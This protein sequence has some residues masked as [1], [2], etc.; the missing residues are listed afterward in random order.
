MYLPGSFLSSLKGL[1]G[2]DK[3]AFE[4]VHASGEQV[5][6]IRINPLK[7]SAPIP[8]SQFPIPWCKYGYYL[9]TRPSCT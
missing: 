6:S 7:P 3:E 4:K 8:N 2:F 5:T 9:K 1:E